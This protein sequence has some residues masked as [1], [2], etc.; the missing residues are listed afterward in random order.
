[1]I[2]FVPCNRVEG[3]GDEYG[4]NLKVDEECIADETKLYSYLEKTAEFS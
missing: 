3:F 2:G 4:V 1:M